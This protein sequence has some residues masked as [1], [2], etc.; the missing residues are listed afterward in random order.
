MNIGKHAAISIT[1][2]L[3]ILILQ[4]NS[5]SHLIYVMIYG[6]RIPDWITYQSS[7]CQVEAE[8][9]PNW[10]NSNLLGLL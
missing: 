5:G 8:V 6:C 4:R 9:P 3:I 2:I 1:N 7:R 10:F